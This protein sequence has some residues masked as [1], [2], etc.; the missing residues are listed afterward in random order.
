MNSLVIEAT[1][2]NG[3]L[4]PSSPLTIKESVK[5]LVTVQVPDEPEVV[6][7]EEAERIV[8]RSQGVF[9]WTGDAE[10]LR[11]IAED[12]EFDWLER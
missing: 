1:Y 3:V 12:P 2:E 11:R 7:R 5:V 4:K 6:T 8:R 9:G 10:T